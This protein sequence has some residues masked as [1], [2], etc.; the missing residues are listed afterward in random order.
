MGFSDLLAILGAVGLAAMLDVAVRPA[1]KQAFSAWLGR[2]ASRAGKIGYGGSAFLDK[3]FGKPVFSLKAVP[4]YALISLCSIALSYTFAVLS[5]PP[6][7]QPLITM[8]PDGMTALSAT[9]LAICFI[10]AIIGDIFSYAQTRLFVRTIDRSRNSV[11]TAGLVPADIIV[12]LAIFFTTFTIARLLCVLAVLSVEPTQKLTH[13]E[14][15]APGLLTAALAE[16]EVEIGS[17]APPISRF[18][19]L[20]A[21][22]KTEAQLRLVSQDVRRNLA[23]Q[24]SRPDALET[25]SY[26]SKRHCPAGREALLAGAEATK[27]SQDLFRSV[28]AEQAQRRPIT[29]DVDRIVGQ[30][31]TAFYA[32]V[33]RAA[34]DQC[35]LEITEIKASQTAAAFIGS[36]GPFN[37]LN[38]AF[39]RTLFDAYSVVGFK[40]APYVSFDPYSSAPAYAASLK[41]Q[42]QNSFLGAFPIDTDRAMLSQYFDDEIAAPEGKL[43]VPFSPMVASAL[44]TSAFLI[45]YLLSLGIAGLRASAVALMQK[46]A[47]AFDTERAVFTTLTVA[48]LAALISLGTVVWLSQALWRLLL[49]Y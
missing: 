26:S 49:G 12:S 25:V 19:I 10:A 48:V 42:V 11:V 36:A 9:I 14:T 47:P 31:G 40:L 46:V 37:A 23:R 34:E 45:L 16:A 7:V 6:H 27:N 5:S 18:A 13:T 28:M 38:A 21:N 3:V 35:L 43:N 32:A 8:F 44:T 1:Q 24:F 22:G 17:D 29:V 33:G 15:F 2:L 20:I 4:R 30:M 41:T 39:E